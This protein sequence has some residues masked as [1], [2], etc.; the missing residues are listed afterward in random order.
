M[1]RWITQ[2]L[3]T[4]AFTDPEIGAH[5][6]VL[7]VR[8]LVDKSGNPAQATREKIEQGLEQLRQG[9]RL[10][11]CCD[12]GISRSNAI[13][14]GILAK[15]S[16]VPL[17]KALREV[18]QKT[19]EQEIK[20]EPL[21]AVRAALAGDRAA[22]RETLPRVLVTG[23]SGFIGAGLLA[24]LG[25]EFFCCA[26]GRNEVDLLGGALELD[27]LV[28]EQGI[29]WIV[30]LANPRVYTSNRAMGESV[31]LLR[32]VL[33]VCRNNDLRLIY[34]SG[35]EVYS[36]YRATELCVNED[37]PLLPRGPYG[38]TKLLCE[39]LIGLHRVQYGVRCA[40]LRSS[41]L[42][43]KGGDRP[44]FIYNFVNK[45][46]GD[47]VIHTHRYRN[48]EPRLDLLHVDDFI[49]AVLAVVRRDFIGTLNLGTGQAV[50]T[51]DL[52]E[53]I[54]QRCGSV[55]PIRY[56][57]VEDYVGNIAMDYA[58]AGKELGWSPQSRWQD[59]LD[60]IIQQAAAQVRDRS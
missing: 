51:R 43:G 30:H 36:G 13:A 33:E 17:E 19:G 12:Y 7:D 3:G 60:E 21:A 10:V 42:Y 16:D 22:A 48:G 32:N 11:V 28:K 56:R 1:I 20:L 14:A 24:R 27:L 4:A 58:R 2:D 45:A 41:P 38:E 37:V 39:Q 18:L 55:S 57:D 47:T 29:N 9:K 46:L 53:W 54:V 35:W 23:G 49:A 34:P 5:L 44:K 26:P 15:Q 59:G 40:V 50:S 6:A 25:E 52:A 31:T 8:D